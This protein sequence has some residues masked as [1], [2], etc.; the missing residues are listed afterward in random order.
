MAQQ[1][2]RSGIRHILTQTRSIPIQLNEKIQECID[3]HFPKFFH[4]DHPYGTLVERL[5][6]NCLIQSGFFQDMVSTLTPGNERHL[7]DF[8]GTQVGTRNRL[9]IEIKY[10]LIVSG[11]SGVE[12]MSSIAQKT[13]ME[14]LQRNRNSRLPSGMKRIPIYLVFIANPQGHRRTPSGLIPM[15]WTYAVMKPSV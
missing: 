8:Y 12:I 2:T 4:I 11:G 15:T 9:C 1:N 14:N 10:G 7:I 5:S 6:I 3:V 13:E